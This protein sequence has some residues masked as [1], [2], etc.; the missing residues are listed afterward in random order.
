MS[1][2]DLLDQD[3]T[4]PEL[5]DAYDEILSAKFQ[6]KSQKGDLLRVLQ[7]IA[8]AQQPLTVNV[9]TEAVSFDDNG[10][11]QKGIDRRYVLDITN[12]LLTVDED[13]IVQFAHLSVKEYLRKSSTKVHSELNNFNVNI[14]IAKSCL[15]YLLSKCGT[16]LTVFPNTYHWSMQELIFTSFG[17]YA[18]LYWPIHIQNAGEIGK[19]DEA[20]NTLLNE[21]LGS[22]TI[23]EWQS[24]L[25]TIRDCSTEF[26]LRW[27]LLDCFRTDWELSMERRWE[28]QDDAGVFYLIDLKNLYWTDDST[29]KILRKNRCWPITMPSESVNGY[30]S[31]VKGKIW[32]QHPFLI[33]CAWGFRNIVKRQVGRYKR[34]MNSLKATGLSIAA[35]F[36]NH[37]IV[38]LLL[39]HGAELQARDLQGKTA[40]WWAATG[41]HSLCAA[42]LANWGLSCLVNDA[43]CME[44]IE[45]GRK[46][47][48]SL[49][50]GI[51]PPSR[52]ASERH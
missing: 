37:D 24:A 40:M 22:G 52:S 23:F 28:R 43:K 42:E 44:L 11:V 14:G 49:E 29:W 50:D 36:G 1:R 9:L 17:E 32:S 46:E 34:Y 21:F 26:I 35:A 27:A 12:C 2:L 31:L 30:N 19:Q 16:L 38:R 48:A 41:D 25:E 5:D 10:Q 45:R 8:G 4:L 13:D 47:L 6:G 3:S 18:L 7:L 39:E 15:L 20:L 51:H 33:A